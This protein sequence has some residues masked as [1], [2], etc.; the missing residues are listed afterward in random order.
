[1]RNR[2]L[3]FKISMMFAGFTLITL[4]FTS[5]LSYFNQLQI[6]KKQR[7]ESI[8][9]IAKYLEKVIQIDGDDFFIFR[10]TLSSISK[11]SRF[12]L[13]LMKRHWHESTIRLDMTREIL[14]LSRSANLS[15]ILLSI[16]LFSESEEMN[17]L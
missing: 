17:L 2:H 5:I 1:M 16:H 11:K 7:E 4:V 15:A 14:R 3:T 9:H 13:N 12:L 6:Y 10:N 8:Q